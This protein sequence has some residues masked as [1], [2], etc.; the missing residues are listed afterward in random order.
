V[1]VLGDDAIKALKKGPDTI[2]DLVKIILGPSGRNVVIGVRG[3]TPTITND[4][5]TISEE[6][7]FEDEID[8]IGARAM[9][10]V[11]MQTNDKVGDGTT[12][13]MVLAQAILNKG[14]EN[15]GD[16]TD[17][18]KDHAQNPIQLK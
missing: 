6:I 11:S 9:R 8:D 4:G 5:V 17:L 3:G 7:F 10:E 2:V 12:M 14:L 15:M 18:I 13:A 16:G 1:I